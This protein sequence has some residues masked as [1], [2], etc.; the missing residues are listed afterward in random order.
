MAATPQPQWT[1]RPAD[2]W[3]PGRVI[4]LVLGI[5]LL[6]LPGLALLA[7]GGVLLWADQAERSDDGY[8]YSAQDGFATEGYAMV[9][10]R[11]DLSTGADWVPLSAALGTARVEITGADD[12]FIGIA[13]LAEGRAY[14]DGVERTVIDD[15]GIDT[16]A[17]A[18]ELVPGGAPSGPPTEQ[19][20]WVA[21]ASGAGAQQ[22]SWEPADGNWLLVV[23]NA[24]GSADVAVTA[25]I[26][27]TAPALDGLAWGLIG[28]G[29][30]LVLMGVLVVVLTV[31]RRPARYAGPPYGGAPATVGPPPAWAP[32]PPVDR[33]SAADNLPT[34]D[35]RQQGPSTG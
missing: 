2:R 34:S 6:I 26:G 21:Q 23:M 12:V 3:G 25:R 10:E 31:R 18:Q 35:V 15:L 19:D 14:L 20:F 17:R 33:R 32:P 1:Y 13:P 24:D 28:G 29:V 22:L 11:I 5:V 16:S 8:L 27:A 30:F 4:A 9:S 7:G